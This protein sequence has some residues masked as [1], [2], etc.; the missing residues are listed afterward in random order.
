M[1]SLLGM[2]GIPIGIPRVAAS[3]TTLFSDNFD[4]DSAFAG[5]VYSWN[6]PVGAINYVPPMSLNSYPAYKSNLYGLY[7]PGGA[8]TCSQ[9]ST[10]N[11]TAIP[12]NSAQ[13]TLSG[14]YY[15]AVDLNFGGYGS[16]NW[17]GFPS[18]IFTGYGAGSKP[19]QG[20]GTVTVSSPN[21]TISLTLTLPDHNTWGLG[22]GGYD[23]VNF[24]RVF[25]TPT[26]GTEATG[27][28]YFNIKFPT[29][30]PYSV[31]FTIYSLS[32]TSMGT[33]G[34]D[35][36]DQC[37]PWPPPPYALAT[38]AIFAVT[39]ERAHSGSNS[40]LMGASDDGYDKTSTSVRLKTSAI[41]YPSPNILQFSMALWLSGSTAGGGTGVCSS[42]NQNT[43]TPMIVLLGD[44]L[45]YSCQKGGNYGVWYWSSATSLGAYSGTYF[46][47]TQTWHTIT[48][49]L[50]ISNS[51]IRYYDLT[52]DNDDLGAIFNNFQGTPLYAGGASKYGPYM[53]GQYWAFCFWI[54]NQAV[55]QLS[56]ATAGNAGAYMYVDDLS[57][58]LLPTAISTSS[59]TETSPISST[60]TTNSTMTVTTTNT[61][62][63]STSQMTS[64]SSTLSTQSLS[65]TT[66]TSTQSTTV[67]AS[68]T[69]PAT[70]TSTSNTQTTITTPTT[71][72]A[73][74]T[75]SATSATSTQT[76]IMST[77]STASI[78]GSL[79]N[80]DGF[81]TSIG[82]WWT[83]THVDSGSGSGS[84][85]SLGVSTTNFHTGPG[86]GFI[87]CWSTGGCEY[88]SGTYGK[89]TATLIPTGST[90]T[91]TFYWRGSSTLKG[92]YNVNAGL[93]GIQCYS[94][95]AAYTT[96]TL[97]TCTATG[98]TVG[99]P[100]P[101]YLGLFGVKTVNSYNFQLYFDDLNVQNGGIQG[102]LTGQTLTA[103]ATA[104]TTTS[105]PVTS[106]VTSSTIQSSTGTSTTSTST[107]HTSTPTTT[108]A[109]S[110]TS[111]TPVTS[112]S[113]SISS[114]K[115]STAT[116]TTSSLATQTSTSNPSSTSSTLTSTW[117]VLTTTS[118]PVTISTYYP[119]MV[120]F[121]HTMA[122]FVSQ[123]LDSTTL[124]S[125]TR[126]N[127]STTSTFTLQTETTTSLA[128][129]SVTQTQFVN[130]TLSQSSTTPLLPQ[131]NI[132]SESLSLL[133]CIWLCTIFFDRDLRRY[134]KQNMPT[135]IRGIR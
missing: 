20:E 133:P 107:I 56:R 108:I 75:S 40:L 15:F 37:D 43:R 62:S 23:T 66:N 117:T 77:P 18:A 100:Y 4:S 112:T 134:L 72:T 114:T 116:T 94:N 123:M 132:V 85:Y 126:Y 101:F 69:T 31:T 17:F 52:V 119:A 96:W 21:N 98:L 42:A 103:T 106:T 131:L 13:G 54:N 127:S 118:S 33:H 45:V 58:S 46:L 78:T 110:Q 24:Y 93:N 50:D 53:S 71:I 6:N 11:N 99:Q 129:S 97:A 59:T 26:S 84:Y 9:G 68:S 109:T 111:T 115:T 89:I 76:T 125:L 130:T 90:L 32:S 67:I 61:S 64:T 104:T 12:V 113:T 49:S 60:A 36:I 39:S 105:T 74:T 73:T 80:S 1:P 44:N 29:S 124:T 88:L 86:A 16:N 135:T 128:E 92:Y 48:I 57:L 28:D 10:W 38:N 5:P 79:A 55:A 102:D 65:S 47:T 63:A 41:P 81:D 7:A 2:P 122:P 121:H 19:T 82:P 22:L 30:T 70:T 95:E 91:V 14:T 87:S 35:K 51:T 27:S 8:S 3:G 120:S 25:I 83:F 34:V